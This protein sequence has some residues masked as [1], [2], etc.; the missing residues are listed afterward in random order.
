MPMTAL[1]DLDNDGQLEYTDGR[2]GGHDLLVQAPQRGALDPSRAGRALALGCGR[3]RAGRGRRWMD[4]FRDRRR[5][6]SQ[7]PER[8]PA[9][10]AHRL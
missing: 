6:V 2:A 7:Q 1:A 9:V 10:R 8:R 3:G 5:L 4:R